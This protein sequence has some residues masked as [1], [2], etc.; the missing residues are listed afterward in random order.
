ML[1]ALASPALG[2]YGPELFPTAA[3]GKANGVL[4]VVS[5]TG[6]AL[7]LIVAGR[8][9]EST[10]RLAD[11]LFVLLPLALVVAILALAVFP[12]TARR[13]LEDINP[14]DAAPPE[15]AGGPGPPPP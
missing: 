4:Q 1:G 3:R 14:E 10:G 12:E 15:A 5:V 6:A 2:A 9:A 13:E 11:G 7:G 8:V